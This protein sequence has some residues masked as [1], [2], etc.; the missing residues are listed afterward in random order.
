MKG[1]F[2]IVDAK[3]M[4]IKLFNFSV[5]M[6]V[7]HT[8]HFENYFNINGKNNEGLTLHQFRIISAIFYAKMNTISQMENI[9]GISKSSLSITIKKLE[10]EGYIVKKSGVEYDGRKVFI[11]V[12]EKGI[13]EMREKEKMMYSLFYEFFNTLNDEK[14]ISLYEGIKNFNKVFIPDINIVPETL[15][16]E[17][18]L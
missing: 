13:K 7:W 9:F 10:K 6:A 16:Q 17:D 4:Y 3:D 11:E 1:G 8:T 2:F 12:T 15:K 18:L 14:K 5:N